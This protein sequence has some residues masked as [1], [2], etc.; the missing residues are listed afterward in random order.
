MTKET[1]GNNPSPKRVILG[2]VIFVCVVF[3]VIAAFNSNGGKD[4]KADGK[5][6]EPTNDEQEANAEEEESEDPIEENAEPTSVQI[7]LGEDSTF[8]FGDFSFELK[9]AEIAEKDGGAVLKLDTLYTND[10]FQDKTSFMQAAIF[11][12]KQ[13]EEELDEV[14]G[15]MSDPNSD[16][17][18]KNDTGIWVP[19]EFEFE[20]KNLEE[21][22]TI[23]VEPMNEHEGVSVYTISLN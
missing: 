11:Y 19:I 18:Y 8:Q 7:D 10:S 1:N 2:A 15:A 21:N 3:I 12:V 23:N 20:L 5:S 4:D 6:S 16:Y 17:Y 14:T 22:I 9:E 13:G